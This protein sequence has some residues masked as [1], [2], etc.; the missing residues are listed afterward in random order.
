MT[1][2][3]GYGLKIVSRDQLLDRLAPM[4]KSHSVVFTNGCFDL[5]HQGH[6]DLLE[7]AATL[8]SVLVV[9]LN[10]DASV[11]GLKGQTRPVTPFAARAAVLAGL[12][13]VDF[14]TGF[15]EPTP[16]ELIRAVAPDVLVKGGD[17]PEDSIVG[18]DEV[19]ARGGQVKS[20]PLLQGHSTTEV[21]ARILAL[22]AA[23]TPGKP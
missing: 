4:R 21:I 7:R 2:Q 3:A 6:V 17:W 5:L 13:C 8:G 19:L 14:V 18:A 22:Q 11:T 15:S 10:T 20:L 23:E 12:G 1:V 16:I 9:G